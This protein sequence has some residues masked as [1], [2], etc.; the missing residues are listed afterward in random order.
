MSINITYD[1]SVIFYQTW[2]GTIA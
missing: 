1:I 2:S